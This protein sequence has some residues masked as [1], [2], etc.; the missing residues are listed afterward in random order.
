MIEEIPLPGDVRFLRD[1]FFPPGD[2]R[3]HNAVTRKMDQAM[4]V[5]RHEEEH[6]HV[7]IAAILP[8]AHGFEQDLSNV[9]VAE[10]VRSLR[11]ATDG[12]EKGRTIA[13]PCR[14]LVWQTFSGGQCV[15]LLD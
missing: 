10:L 3:F 13:N 11:R 14:R 4:E 12:D 9:G 5:I 7:P 6:M 1:K 8:E 2:N 15:W